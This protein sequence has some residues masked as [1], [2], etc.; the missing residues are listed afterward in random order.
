MRTSAFAIAAL[1]DSRCQRLGPRWSPPRT[2]RLRG[3]PDLVRDAEDELT[4]VRRTQ[5]GV[6]AELVD[7]VRR[8]LDQ[9]VATVGGGL[10]DGCLDHG[11]MRRTHGVDTDGFAGLVPFDRVG[12]PAGRVQHLSI[13]RSSLIVRNG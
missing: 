11:R 13:M 3:K 2:T 12:E 1:A 5:T 7:L 10:R 8:R 4:E 6:A 9:H